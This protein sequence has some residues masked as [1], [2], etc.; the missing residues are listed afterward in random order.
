MHMNVLAQKPGRTKWT[1]LLL[2]F[3][4][5]LL[6]V[7]VVQAADPNINIITPQSP[8]AHVFIG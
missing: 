8:P 7:P 1:V 5:V 4:A 2:L 6:A 3:M